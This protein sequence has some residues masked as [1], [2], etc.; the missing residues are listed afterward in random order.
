M[1]FVIE[2]IALWGH[3]YLYNVMM[4]DLKY[5]YS[6]LVTGLAIGCRI[7]FI[8]ILSAAPCGRLDFRWG[9]IGLVYCC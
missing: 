3:R 1:T 7:I 6:L 2:R 8:R 4:F 5:K 9:C